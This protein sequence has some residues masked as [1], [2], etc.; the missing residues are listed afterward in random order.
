M[1]E[2]SQ[3]KTLYL[4][5]PTFITWTMELYPRC[6]TSCMKNTGKALI[7]LRAWTFTRSIAAVQIREGNCIMGGE[8]SVESDTWWACC[9][10]A[11]FKKIRNFWME[12]YIGLPE[13]KLG[14]ENGLHHTIEDPYDQIRL[15]F[16]CLTSSYSHQHLSD[17]VRRWIHTT[18]GHLSY[19]SFIPVI[20]R[21]IAIVWFAT[22]EEIIFPHQTIPKSLDAYLSSPWLMNV[23]CEHFW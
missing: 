11:N 18:T 15:Y 16:S 10:L 2:E 4:T 17:G 3:L 23:L 20:H 8:Y 1:M 5:A 7:C 13:F 9:L 19:E 6:T 22:W 21:R 14:V 12:T